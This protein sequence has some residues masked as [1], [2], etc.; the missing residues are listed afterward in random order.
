MKNSKDSIDS[1][2][3]ASTVFS[4]VSGHINAHFPALSSELKPSKLKKIKSVLDTFDRR[5]LG[6]KNQLQMT[7]VNYKK[8]LIERLQAVEL[9]YKDPEEASRSPIRRFEKKMEQL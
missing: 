7:E 2:F 3:K 8:D 6:S 9:P 4:K 5:K 1:I